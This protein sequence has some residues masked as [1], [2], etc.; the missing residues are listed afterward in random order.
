[1]GSLSF[2]ILTSFIESSPMNTDILVVIFIDQITAVV[3]VPTQ[4]GACIRWHRAAA[5]TRV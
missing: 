5:K 2:A 3:A 4:T 1:M